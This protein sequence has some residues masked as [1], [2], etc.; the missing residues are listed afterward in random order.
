MDVNMYALS[1]KKERENWDDGRT[2]KAKASYG[3]E[4]V[5]NIS[6]QEL[7]PVCKTFYQEHVELSQRQDK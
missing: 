7:E 4:A 6:K 2:K 5:S 1:K 3:E